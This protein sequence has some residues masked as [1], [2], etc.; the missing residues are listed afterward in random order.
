MRRSRVS[1]AVAM[2]VNTWRPVQLGPVSPWFT[3]YNRELH[4]QMTLGY[5]YGRSVKLN[6]ST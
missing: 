1:I 6:S 3:P 5:R 2:A 4:K